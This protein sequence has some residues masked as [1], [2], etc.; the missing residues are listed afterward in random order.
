MKATLQQLRIHNFKAFPEFD[1]KL[2]GRHLLL[3]G[4]N[5]S[6]KSSLYWALYTFLQSSRKSAADVSR[7]FTPAHS[8]ALL[9]INADPAANPGE[10]SLTI[11]ETVSGKDTSYRIG[12]DVHDTHKKPPILKAD[13]ASDFITYRFFFGFSNFR[14]SERFN[15][16]PIFEREI[17]PFCVSTSGGT[18]SPEEMWNRIKSGE[19]NPKK[20]KGPAAAK[21]YDLF[22]QETD[23]FAAI[24]PGIVDSI[25]SEAQRLYDGYFKEADAAKL[26]LKLGLVSPAAYDRQ[27]QKFSPPVIEFGIQLGSKTIT[28]PQTFLNE[29]KLTQLAL[30]VRLAASL[31]NL[32]QSDLKLLVLDDLL[33]SL[34]MNNRMKV[35]EILLSKNFANYQK[36]ILTHDLGFF[37]EFR[38]TIG[39]EHPDWCFESLSGDSIKGITK[40][41]EKTELQKAEAYLHGY[42]LDEAAICL[43]KATEG[44]VLRY[45][46]PT[47]VPGKD[48]ATL[49][50]NLRA[51]R[52]KL[53]EKLPTQLYDTVLSSTS[54]AHREHLVPAGDAD[55]DALPD[56]ALAD[57]EAIKY[58]RKQLRSLLK[59]E[60][61]KAIENAKLIDEVLKM[62]ERVLNPGA[63]AGQ[64]PLYET[65]VQKAFDLIAKLEKCFTYPTIAEASI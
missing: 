39:A 30:S 63:H 25:S 64:A 8:E 34:D 56:L 37:Q 19:A 50:Q 28:K 49:T 51:A 41:T 44:T 40:R 32:Q 45:L 47:I 3:Y 60:H 10:I 29:A 22:Q 23:S 13:L 11:R 6:G 53:L 65:E 7:Y 58:Q 12:K 5:G 27:K 38:R 57:Q 26:T 35:V 18:Q 16:W 62:T 15:I 46:K 61:W 59:N 24:L 55:V 2:E 20:Y 21:A 43:R 9:N 48:F 33:I 1:L 17:L 31:V 4:P 42:N 36:I 52:N 54:V 14:N